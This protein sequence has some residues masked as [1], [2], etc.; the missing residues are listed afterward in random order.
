M[1]FSEILLYLRENKG[2]TQKELANACGVS[3]QCISALESGVR[4]PTGSTILS[5]ADY[6]EVSTDYLLG[7]ADDFGNITVQGAS[8]AFSA[9]ELRLVEDYRNLSKPLKK[10]LQE[11]LNIWKSSPLNDCVKPRR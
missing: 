5:L 4:N 3:S 1:N 7:R 6:F 9:E 11:T 2:I 8:R 10:L